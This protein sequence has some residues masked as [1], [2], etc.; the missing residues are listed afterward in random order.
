[1]LHRLA[2][3]LLMAPQSSIAL[4]GPRLWRG[5][6]QGGD[7]I[8]PGDTHVKGSSFPLTRPLSGGAFVQRRWDA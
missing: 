1:M 5:A 7:R 3:R 2:T 8:A 4:W 6:T